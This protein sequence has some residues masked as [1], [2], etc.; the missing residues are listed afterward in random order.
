MTLYCVYSLLS[1]LAAVGFADNAFDVVVVV[2][3]VIGEGSGC[4]DGG[5]VDSAGL[6]WVLDEYGCLSVCLS[7]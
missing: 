6:S 5:G 4:G 3:V 1:Y 7:M 2:V